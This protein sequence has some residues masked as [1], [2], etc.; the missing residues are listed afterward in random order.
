[1]SAA[2][3]Q[4]LATENDSSSDEEPAGPVDRALT[5][6]PGWSKAQRVTAVGRKYWRFTGPP[7]SGSRVMFSLAAAWGE[8]DSHQE[9]AKEGDSDEGSVLAFANVENE[10]ARNIDNVGPSDGLG[11][12]ET[13]EEMS[14]EQAMLEPMASATFGESEGEPEPVGVF[15]Y[16]F[17]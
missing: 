13:V 6:P 11:A 8:F 17:C 12:H 10:L 5:M 16:F 3:V 15:F 2:Q 7:D 14:F 4:R 1:M 9:S